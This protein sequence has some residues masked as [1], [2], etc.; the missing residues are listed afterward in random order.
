MN[1]KEAEGA[2]A[3]ILRQLEIDNGVIVKT[4]GLDDVEVT[5]ID[6][7]RRQFSRLV[8]IECSPAPGMHWSQIKDIRRF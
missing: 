4:I 8:T 2:I 5:Q 7:D 1:I 3:H 6:D